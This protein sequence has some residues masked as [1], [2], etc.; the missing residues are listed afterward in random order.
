MSL[1]TSGQHA[2][3]RTFTNHRIHLRFPF[4]GV[5]DLTAMRSGHHL[6]AQVSEISSRGCYLETPN[7]LTTGTKVQ[8]RLRHEGRSCELSGTVRYAHTGLG[9]GVVFDPKYTQGFDTLDD[10][11]AE[12]VDTQTRRA[13]A[14]SAA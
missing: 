5:A 10:W 3:S 11:L 8:L 2:S 7:P 12:L 9:M 4:V 13:V 1:T 14:N 6:T